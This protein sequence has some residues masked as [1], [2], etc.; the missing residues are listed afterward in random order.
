MTRLHRAL[1]WAY[2]ACIVALIEAIIMLLVAG[3]AMMF[4]GLSIL[5]VL[6]CLIDL[7]GLS[8]SKREA[9]RNAPRGLSPTMTATFATGSTVLIAVALARGGFSHPQIVALCASVV[10]SWA[11]TVDAF[12]QRRGKSSS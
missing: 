2:L 6:A 12:D 9:R 5:M 4:V 8:P 11:T 7:S 10:W 1:G 3:D